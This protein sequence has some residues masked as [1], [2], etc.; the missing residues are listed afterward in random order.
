MFFKG[1]REHLFGLIDLHPNLWQVCQLHRGAIFI[2]EF[3]KIKTIKEEITV[4]CFET[5][6]GEVERLLHQ[7]GVGV[8]HERVGLADSL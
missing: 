8:V 1:V 6:L 3:P 2:Y 5:L 7:V 4:F